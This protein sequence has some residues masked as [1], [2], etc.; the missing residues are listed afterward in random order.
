[1]KIAILTSGTLPV[2]AVQGGAVENLIDFYLDYNERQKEHDITIFSMYAPTVTSHYLLKSSVNHFIYIRTNNVVNRFL[3]KVY[4]YFYRGIYDYFI[5]FFFEKAFKLLS[6][7]KFDLIILENR[8]GYAVKLNKRLPEIPIIVHLHFD[9]LNNPNS[10]SLFKDVKGIISV[11]DFLYS[12]ASPLLQKKCIT[13]HNGIDL[14][15]FIIPDTSEKCEYRKKYNINADDIV[16]VYSGRISPIKGVK[17]LI[18]ALIIANNSQIKLL[19][20]GGSF[21]G[22]QA[23][24]DEYTIKVKELALQIK[25]QIIFTGFR[26]YSEIPHLLSIADIAVIPSIC[27]DAFPTTVLEAM[28]VGLP[29]IASRRGGIPEQVNED[30]AILLSTDANFTQALSEA[31]LRLS[32]DAHLR[33]RMS[34][35][36]RKKSTEFEKDYYSQKFFDAIQ[37][38]ISNK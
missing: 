23:I 14:S 2:P 8:P 36:S 9:M 5:E 26:P 13:V 33:H 4:S 11:S 38:I 29:I 22:A 34:I 3:R 30:N 15:R 19:I 18:E 31:I 12:K 24:D 21:Y 1:M 20:I 27:D 37:Q 25:D 35:S 32:K 28:A 16:I 17:E 10:E 7:D 6:R